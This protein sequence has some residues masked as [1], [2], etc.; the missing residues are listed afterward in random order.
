MS[1]EIDAEEFRRR[2]NQHSSTPTD[3][4]KRCPHC[5]SINIRPLQP[6]KVA[7][8]VPRGAYMCRARDCG[9]WFDTPEVPR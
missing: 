6:E 4:R 5:G 1:A 3:E 7:G 9:E 2:L 8:D